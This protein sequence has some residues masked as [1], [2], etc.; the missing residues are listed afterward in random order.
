M[1]ENQVSAEQAAADQAAIEAATKKANE[2][3]IAEEVKRKIEEKARKD[4]LKAEQAAE[5][6][7]AKETEKA[8][9]KAAKEEAA[10][11]AKA[12]KE[13]SRMPAANDVR[14]PKPEGLC[15]KVWEHADRLSAALGQPVSIKAL[16]ESTTAAG[17]SSATT[18]VQYARWRKYY[19]IAGRIVAPVAAAAETAQAGTEAV[20]VVV[21]ETPASE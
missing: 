18:R 8:A 17:L 13:A 7:L 2:D 10:A 5:R 6:K 16:L 12:A 19:G 14:R 3:K 15:G 1:N 21:E 4:A 11:A 9:K 20:V